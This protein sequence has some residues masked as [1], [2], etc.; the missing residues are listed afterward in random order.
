MIYKVAS[1]YI[2]VYKIRQKGNDLRI[3]MYIQREK[4]MFFSCGA[5]LGSIAGV[6]KK[7]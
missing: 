3:F 5:K 2:F 4:F 6:C 1:T 7:K